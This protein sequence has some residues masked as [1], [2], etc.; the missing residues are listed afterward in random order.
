MSRYVVEDCT[1]PKP[2][3]GHPALELCNTIAMW[4]L[5]QEHDY[6]V[7]GH[8]LAVWARERGLVSQADQPLADPTDVQLRDVKRLR[9]HLHDVVIA[10]EPEDL[11]LTAIHGL[12]ASATR[13]A[14]YKVSGARLTLVAADAG[15]LVVDRAALAVHDLLTSWGPAAVGHC[16]GEPCG[17]VFLDPAHRRRWCEMAVCGNRA[18]ARR[19]A[20]RHQALR[21]DGAGRGP[22]RSAA[23]DNRK[24]SIA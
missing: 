16:G 13:R 23:A 19:Y 17:W 8:V 10:A 5:P 15:H 3:A 9:Q 7:D 11:D 14:S 18:K 20:R 21:D 22:R 4:G 12:V 1:L 24:V 2:I 6:L